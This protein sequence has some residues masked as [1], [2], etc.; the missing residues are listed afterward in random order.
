[1]TPEIKKNREK[2]FQLSTSLGALRIPDLR[3]VGTSTL[4]LASTA[5]A[6][7]KTFEKM[8]T[9]ARKKVFELLLHYS[10]KRRLSGTIGSEMTLFPSSS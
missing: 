2:N 5:Q 6:H 8:T 9:A 3:K 10:S 4:T 1:M 7:W